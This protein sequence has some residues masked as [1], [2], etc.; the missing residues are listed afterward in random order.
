MKTGNFPLDQ[1]QMHE[2]EKLI[3]SLDEKGMIWLHGYIQGKLASSLPAGKDKQPAI[4]GEAAITILFG[5]HTG[6]SKKI[7]GRLQ[8]ELQG[9]GHQARLI[10]ISEY[11]PKDIVNERTLLLII[12]THGEGDPPLAAEEFYEFIHSSRARK[13]PDLAFAILALGDKSYLNFCKTGADLDARFEALGGKRLLARVDCDVNYTSPSEKWIYEVAAILHTA[14]PASSTIKTQI[15]PISDPVDLP[16]REHPVEAVLLNKIK[17]SGRNSQKKTY[18]LEIRLPDENM[19]Y[20]PGDALGVIPENSPALADEIIHLLKSTPEMPVIFNGN[21]GSLGN[22]LVHEAELTRLTRENIEA[23]AR[24]ADD[25]KL[26]EMLNQPSKLAD[27]LY[28]CTWADLLHEYPA[29]IGTEQFLALLRPIQARL[30]SIASSAM[31]NPGEVHLTVSQLNADSANKSWKGTCS[32]YLSGL[33]DEGSVMKVFFETNE[34]FRLPSH[35]RDIIMIGP[36]TGVAPFRAFLQEREAAGAK[37]KN[38]LFF[39]DRLFTDDFLYQTEWQD[40]HKKSLLHRIDLAFSRDQEHKIY[41]Q[42]R[43]MEGSRELYAWLENGALLY[44]CGDMKHMSHDVNRTLAE[45]VEKEGGIS[46]DKAKE[47]IKSLRREK[48]YL[49]DVY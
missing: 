36:G 37:G 45:I 28:A 27:V 7:A 11:K 35:D 14:L 39:G 43:M 19:Y 8:K 29:A 25:E 32:N 24:L 17:L 38:W 20:H 34:S 41:V 48:R 33:P 4:Q 13:L 47:Y 1:A 22:V 42:H 15:Q 26:N 5:T 40:W 18:H 6:N 44:V 30:Y 31:A 2:I 3:G 10:D 16:G 23:Y 9:G 12:S 49:E 21:S 46:A